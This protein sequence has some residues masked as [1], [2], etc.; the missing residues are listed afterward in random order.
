M[1]FGHCHHCGVIRWW[2]GLCTR[3]RK[4]DNR[5]HCPDWND[6]SRACR[7]FFFREIEGQVLSSHLIQYWY[8]LNLTRRKEERG[9]DRKDQRTYEETTG[10]LRAV[11]PTRWKHHCFTGCEWTSGK[12]D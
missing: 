4:P 8:Y 9:E 5:A 10:F 7:T 3:R 11:F 1:V 2:L 12:P 6:L